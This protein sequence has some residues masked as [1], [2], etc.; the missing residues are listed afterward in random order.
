MTRS[1][2]ALGPTLQRLRKAAGL[3]LRELQEGSGVNRSVISRVES[4][5]YMQPRPETL[6][7]LAE[8]IGAD[9][10]ELLTAAGYTSAKADGL[11]N[12]P[13]YLRSKYGHLPASARKE[14]AE[15]VTRLEA[16]YGSKPKPRK[17]TTAKK[18][19]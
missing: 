7:R 13:I 19:T 11:P 18:N 12:L 6:T 5:E 2:N 14:L 17:R 10:S 1:T 15:F 8:A 16:E 4:G 3:S 9:A